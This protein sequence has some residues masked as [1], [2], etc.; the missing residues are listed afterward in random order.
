MMVV[1]ASILHYNVGVTSASSLS[2]RASRPGAT[3]PRVR[4]DIASYALQRRQKLPLNLA[5][6]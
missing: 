1:S 2:V 5:L 6:G 4:I 3:R